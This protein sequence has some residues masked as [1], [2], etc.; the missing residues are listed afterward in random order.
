MLAWGRGRVLRNFFRLLRAEG[1]RLVLTLAVSGLLAASL[2]AIAY[3]AV[4]SM[5][6]QPWVL[7]AAD[8][9]AHYATLPVGLLLLAALVELAGRTL[10]PEPDSRYAR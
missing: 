3:V 7:D 5:P 8:S 4:L 2:S 9:Y 6:A 1:V 10:P